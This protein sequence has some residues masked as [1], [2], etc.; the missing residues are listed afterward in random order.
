MRCVCGAYG[1]SGCRIVS[2]IASGGGSIILQLVVRIEAAGVLC[3][4]VW[5]TLRGV[6]VVGAVVA[7]EWSGRHGEI[8]VAFG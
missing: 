2:L 1:A 6:N 3:V 8:L 7:C 4:F 5:R